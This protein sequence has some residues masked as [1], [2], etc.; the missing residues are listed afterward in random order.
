MNAF[1]KATLVGPTLLLFT[2]LAQASSPSL[3]V[4]IEQ[5]ARAE[6]D[7]QLAAAGLTEPQVDLALVNPRPAPACAQPVAIE[8]LD[9]RSTLRMRF[10]ARCS[11]TP[12]WR[13]EYV[14]RARVSA[15]VVVAS[16]SIA[17]NETLSNAQVTL[18]RRDI[19]GIADPITNPQEIIGQNSRRMLRPGDILRSGQLSSPV[20]VRRGDAVTMVARRD[21]IEVSTAGEALDAGAQGAIVRVRNV[22]SGQVMRMRVAGAGTVE[23]V[24]MSSGR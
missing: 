20:L 4:Q 17:A 18:E 15:M 16:T 11:D 24:E 5:V 10:L 2:V 23:P 21:G 13:Y 19:S 14:V 7:K 8:P 22:G 9:T 6:L 3:T 12:G 1:Y